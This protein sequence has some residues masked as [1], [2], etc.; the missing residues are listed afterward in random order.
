MILIS[1]G[2]TDAVFQ[3]GVI[4]NQ[5]NLYYILGLL[6]KKSTHRHYSFCYNEVLVF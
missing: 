2:L 6:L 4:L 5:L 3:E 1:S